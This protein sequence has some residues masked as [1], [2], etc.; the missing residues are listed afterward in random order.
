MALVRYSETPQVSG[1][2]YKEMRYLKK[3]PKKRRMFAALA[4]SRS[5]NDN[6][7]RN[8]ALREIGK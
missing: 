4:E 2:E 1:L 8:K 5:V 6:V 3:H 7:R